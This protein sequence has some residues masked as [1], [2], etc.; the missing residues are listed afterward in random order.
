MQ[1]AISSTDVR[2]YW[3][4]FLDTVIYEKPQIVKRN[5]DHLLALSIEQALFLLNHIRFQAQYMEEDNGSITATIDN[6]TFSHR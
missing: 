1:G 6:S 4:K 2:K 5:R 3:S